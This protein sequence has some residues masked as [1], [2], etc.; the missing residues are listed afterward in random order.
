MTVLAPPPL[1]VP[2]TVTPS[3]TLSTPTLRLA[4][5]KAKAIAYVKKTWNGTR[6]R[7]SCARVDT[8]SFRCTVRYT[9]K[10][11]TRRVKVDVYRDGARSART[12]PRVIGRSQHGARH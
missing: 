8:Q 2:S 9:R 6:V 5:A 11:K 1:I 10:T 3:P 4:T 7:V 12:E